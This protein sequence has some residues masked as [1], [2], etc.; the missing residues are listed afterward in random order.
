MKDEYWAPEAHTIE[1]CYMK[2]ALEEEEESQMQNFTDV[3]ELWT[4]VSLY[5]NTGYKLVSDLPEM[6]LRYSFYCKSNKLFC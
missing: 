1:K 3:I 5:I 2:D 6:Q 4:A